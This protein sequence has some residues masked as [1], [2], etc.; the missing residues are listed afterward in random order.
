[1]K[2]I[3]KIDPTFAV[4]TK[5]NRAGLVFYS[6]QETVFSL[7]GLF[8]EDGKYRRLPETVARRV[9]EGVLALHANTAGGR[10]RFR[11]NSPYVAIHAEM[12]ALGKMPHFA[13]TGSCGFDLYE[14]I[15]GRQI[16]RGSFIP[17]FD[18]ENTFEAIVE[19][20]SRDYHELTLH[21][22]LYSE[23]CALY[24]G[25]DEQAELQ[26]PPAYTYAK[27]VVYY[28]SSITQGG[29]A[30]RP[31]NAY[32]NLISLALDTEQLNLGFSGSARA[33]DAVTEYI[34]GLDMSVLVYDYDY[35][36][37]DPT[38]LEATH[39]KMFRAVRAAHPYLPIVMMS[40]PKKPPHERAEQD[41][42]LEIIRRTY[43]N[44][45]DAG[46]EN[47]WLI[48]GDE[49]LGDAV[50]AATVDNCH[51]NDLGFWFMAQ[52]LIPLIKTI[53]NQ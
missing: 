53:L 40:L 23:V 29:C 46:D 14:K 9:S 47:V 22:P 17:P 32:P 13:L 48:S 21:F 25:L 39:E 51:P 34:C 20:G 7:S 50:E 24:I 2:P 19:L 4:Q 33:E 35:N 37:P 31:G 5:L 27:P 11:T 49:L 44:A 43:R 1:M 38:Y 30:S 15:D 18:V 10:I 42:R 36:A 45:L 16:Y 41:K 28:G 8:W 6:A 3:E 26:P 52:K 12:G